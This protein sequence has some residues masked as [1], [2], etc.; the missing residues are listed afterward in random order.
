MCHPAPSREQGCHAEGHIACTLRRLRQLCDTPP[1]PVTCDLSTGTNYIQLIYTR[2]HIHAH[3]MRG[4]DS[5]GGLR[6]PAVVRD[7]RPSSQPVHK[8]EHQLRKLYTTGSTPAA[9]TRRVESKTPALLPVGQHSPRWPLNHG[10]V[11]TD[12]RWVPHGRFKKKFE[13][14]QGPN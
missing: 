7:R 4:P 3:A 2:K 9:Q 14:V 13:N 8:P 11:T 1:A 5:G 6:L 12:T 10:V